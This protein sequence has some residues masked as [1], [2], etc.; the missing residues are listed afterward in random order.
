MIKAKRFE[1]RLAFILLIVAL[2]QGAVAQ[3]S[4]AQP[5]AASPDP[6]QVPPSRNL[7]PHF[8]TVNG[9]KVLY[10][11]GFPFAVLAVEIPWWDLVI[12][13]YRETLTA[14]DY[15]YPAA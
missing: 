15:L 7:M 2:T 5:N 8:E 3:P 12:G 14:Y 6:W 1:V 10:V 9:R 13:H 4:T 11:D